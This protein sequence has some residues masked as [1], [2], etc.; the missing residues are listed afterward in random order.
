MAGPTIARVGALQLH[1]ILT[2]RGVTSLRSVAGRN[3]AQLATPAECDLD[4][5]PEQQRQYSEHLQFEDLQHSVHL[6]HYLLLERGVVV[7]VVGQ[8][9]STGTYF[10]SLCYSFENALFWVFA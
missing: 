2:L 1:M 5:W 10:V 9:S 7:V 8:R 3:Y 4:R 6:R